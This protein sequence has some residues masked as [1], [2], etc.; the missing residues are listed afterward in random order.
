MELEILRM[1]I[2]KRK[3]KLNEPF[4]RHKAYVIL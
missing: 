3:G 1:L 2:E 4:K